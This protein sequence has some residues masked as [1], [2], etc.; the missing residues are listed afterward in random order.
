MGIPILRVRRSGIFRRAAST[1][2]LNFFPSLPFPILLS[3]PVPCESVILVWYQRNSRLLSFRCNNERPEKQRARERK[4]KRDWKR[5]E[6]REGKG[7]TTYPFS[8]FPLQRLSLLP[9]ETKPQVLPYFPSVFPLLSCKSFLRECSP[10]THSTIA[11]SAFSL[12]PLIS[13]VSRLMFTPEQPIRVLYSQWISHSSS[14][15]G[16]RDETLDV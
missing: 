6:E 13:P 9:I 2:A 4:R 12:F 10:V 8:Y 14:R 7:S 1:S 5:E 15:A 11:H 16:A 3:T